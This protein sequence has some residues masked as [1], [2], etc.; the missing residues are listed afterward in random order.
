MHGS[1]IPL[2]PKVQINPSL[3][4]DLSLFKNFANNEESFHAFLP[5]TTF[6]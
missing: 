3:T 4:P 5:T 6:A 2:N 1:G